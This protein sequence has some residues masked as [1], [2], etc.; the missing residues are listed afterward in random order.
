[1]GLFSRRKEIE[2]SHDKVNF[3][4]ELIGV[5][6]LLDKLGPEGV[7][8]RE[9]HFN[10]YMHEYSDFPKK[11]WV[12]FKDDADIKMGAQIVR[13]TAASVSD[14]YARRAAENRKLLDDLARKRAELTESPGP[15]LFITTTSAAP[16]LSATTQ[17]TTVSVGSTKQVSKLSDA[18]K[19]KL[20]ASTGL[21]INSDVALQKAKDRVLANSKSRK[22][23]LAGS[24][25]ESLFSADED[26]ATEIDIIAKKIESIEAS[27]DDCPEWSGSCPSLP[28]LSGLKLRLSNLLDLQKY[29]DRLNAMIAGAK[30]GLLVA[31]GQISA[32]LRCPTYLAQQGL[33]GVRTLSKVGA[34]VSGLK[35]T[36]FAEEFMTALNASGLRKSVVPDSS[37]F[38]V[39]AVKGSDKFSMAGLTALFTSIKDGDVDFNPSALLSPFRDSSGQTRDPILPDGHEERYSFSDIDIMQQLASSDMGQVGTTPASKDK[40][41]NLRTLSLAMEVD[42][43]TM[44][45]NNQI[46]DKAAGG[47]MPETVINTDGNISRVASQ[48]SGDNTKKVQAS[49]D[50]GNFSGITNS[51]IQSREMVAGVN[52]GD[53]S[54]VDDRYSIIDS[55]TLGSAIAA[56]LPITKSIPALYGVTY[57]NIYSGH[58]AA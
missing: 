54:K 48:I 56:K 40:V 21:D 49:V 16:N 3:P 2:F 17:E 38:A 23:D 47:D 22:I 19:A 36:D 45:M 13:D 10:D 33:R 39:T 53:M 46:A 28:G 31:G 14:E 32:W 26:T 44:L 35:E 42:Q 27:R 37:K 55:D 25:E 41:G 34:F 52:V 5:T 50:A 7:T 29:E 20:E 58:Q 15:K 24:K 4:V 57:S 18:E 8:E 1:M 11:E 9:D 43:S 12:V 30:A 6:T 51:Q